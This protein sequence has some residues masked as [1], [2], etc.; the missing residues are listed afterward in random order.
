MLYLPL[1]TLAIP[2]CTT[3]LVMDPGSSLIIPFNNTL[4]LP[5]SFNISLEA[6][7]RDW[8]ATPYT[9]TLES[10]L[11][12]TFTSYGTIIPSIRKTEIVPGRYHQYG[13]SGSN[14][15]APV[16]WAW[17]SRHSVLAG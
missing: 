9:I 6:K 17:E 13:R 4:S 15:P 7:P 2:I 10:G 16:Y 5:P 12:I 1:L 3:A 8:Q 11:S 14:L